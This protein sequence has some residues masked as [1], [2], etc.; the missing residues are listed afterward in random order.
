MRENHPPPL[1]FTAFRS[2]FFLSV[3]ESFATEFCYELFVLQTIFSRNAAV[4]STFRIVQQTIVLA[5]GH[6]NVVRVMPHTRTT[7]RCLS[8]AWLREQDVLRVA[9]LERACLKNG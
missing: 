9:L 5:E 8:S 2:S 6:S 3:F 7:Y 1:I 4:Q